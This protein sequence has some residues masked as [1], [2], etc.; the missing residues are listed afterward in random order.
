MTRALFWTVFAA[1]VYVLAVFLYYRTTSLGQVALLDAREQ[2]VLARQIA[3]GTI[4]AEP[5]Y[6]APLWAVVL[7]IFYRL[8]LNDSGVVLA[9]QLL[10]LAL[11]L[12]SAWIIYA[13]ALKLWSRRDGAMMAGVLYAVYPVALYLSGDLLDATFAQALLCGGLYFWATAL[14]GGGRFTV[15]L[16]SG[17]MLGLAT[18]T[19]PQLGA[20]ALGAAV[21]LLLLGVKQSPQRWAFTGTAV[22]LALV[23]LSFGFIEKARTGIFYLFP[24]QGGYNL[25]CANKPGSTGEYY[26][27][28]ME[29]PNLP[30]GSNPARAEAEILYQQA[31]GEKAGTYAQVDR[32]WKARFV[33][34]AQSSPGQLAGHYFYK[35][36]ALLHNHEGYN[37]KNFACEK[38]Q[39]PL[40]RFNPLGFVFISIMALSAVL[41]YRPFPREIAWV[42]ALGAFYWL[43]EALFYTSDRFRL[44]LVPFVL[45]LAA[46]APMAFRQL[47]ECFIRRQNMLL[48]SAKIGV[49]A[50]WGIVFSMP[51][52]GM[53]SSNTI[54]ADQLL[55]AQAALKTGD[56]QQAEQLSADLIREGAATQAT[57]EC[58]LESR[59]NNLLKGD[60][61]ATRPW[62]ENQLLL[63]EK[64]HVPSDEAGFI[65]GY[66][67]WQ[68]EG[69]TARWHELVRSGSSNQ[70]DKALAALIMANALNSSESALVVRA[71]NKGSFPVLL[72]AATR[73]DEKSK[74]QLVTQLGV[75]PVQKALTTWQ[76]LFTRPEGKIS[77]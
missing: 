28:T 49:L 71:Q 59:F 50:L 8:E 3:T 18:M 40:L 68:L 42:M 57:I 53:L 74:N 35:L 70:A 23:W 2:Q 36:A 6:R 60:H 13:T 72:A 54:Q 38:Q 56:D 29:L 17:I 63:A 64:L 34:Y 46:G 41:F 19:R 48:C 25:W 31:T 58:L 1:V 14:A 10:N 15:G 12:S 55:R 62:C 20:V 77:P 33:A 11:H 65:M 37:N 75:A 26:A 61:P 30:D 66:C 4:S 44:S 32:Y 9:G 51:W 52:P 43:G 69:K 7:S 47:R 73:G 27:Q 22:A 16:L 45:I 5:F 24:A 21:L 67:E 76:K 39:Y